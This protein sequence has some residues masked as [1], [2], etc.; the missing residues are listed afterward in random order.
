MEV[1]EIKE[2]A[3]KVKENGEKRDE[4]RFEMIC[5]LTLALLA[6]ILAIAELGG[7]KFRTDG[8]KINIEKANAYAWYDSKGIKKNLAEGQ[9]D[10]LISLQQAGSISREQ[11]EGIEKNVGS[12]EKKIQKYEKEQDEILEG[13]KKVGP[14][15]WVQDVD[16][17]MGKVIGAREYEALAES[18]EKADGKIDLA[19]LF[20]QISLVIGAISLML[21]E[22]K[23]KLVLYFVMVGFGIIGAIAAAIG[24]M[25]GLPLIL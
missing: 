16:G 15:N 23:F 14:S 22:D 11:K 25:S 19:V 20:L 24:L 13:S 8:A 7:G 3:E 2:L 12:L 9:R 21:K 10:I 5:G 6:A 1:N 4:G 18:L 17:K